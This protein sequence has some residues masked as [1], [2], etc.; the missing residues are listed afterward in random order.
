[1]VE[2]ALIAV[3]GGSLTLDPGVV[4]QPTIR[5]G[6]EGRLFVL[7]SIENAKV[8]ERELGLNLAL[9][10]LSRLSATDAFRLATPW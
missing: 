5:I 9:D 4:L 6:V 7:R 3:S 2:N 1:M 8:P 10:L